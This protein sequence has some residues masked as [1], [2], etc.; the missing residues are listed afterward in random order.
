VGASTP[1]V[2]DLSPSIT[3]VSDYGVRVGDEVREFADVL[4]VPHKSLNQFRLRDAA[5]GETDRPLDYDRLIDDPIKSLVA[6]DKT[7]FHDLK[8][9]NVLRLASTDPLR[10]SKRDLRV[11]EIGCANGGL[12][13]RLE[14]HFEDVWGCDPSAAM[15]RQAGRKAIQMPSPTRI[16]VPDRAYD[17]AICACVYHHVSRDLWERHLTEIRRVLRPNGLL[18]VFEHNPHNPLTRLVVRLCPIDESAVLVPRRKMVQAM[19]EAGFEQLRSFYYLFL[20]QVLQKRFARLER[21]LSITRLGG[22][23]C[24]A[25][26]NSQARSS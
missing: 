15:V 4:G 6:K 7:Y 22:Q 11:L 20:P 25:G 19:T 12:M 23:Y 16:P 21:Y 5:S 13:R 17:I 14:R 26:R 2:I 18:I 24:I 1:Q 3:S 8:A 9:D 10:T